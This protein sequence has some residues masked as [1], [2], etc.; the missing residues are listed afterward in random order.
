MAKRLR[1]DIDPSQVNIQNIDEFDAQTES[2]LSQI[3]Q[4]DI[5]SMQNH[6]LKTQR[7]INNLLT[8]L[9]DYCSKYHRIGDQETYEN[10]KNSQSNPLEGT[11]FFIRS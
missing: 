6:I 3:I 2:T 10:Y 7:D 9:S 4:T 1:E 5:P 11:I 8:V